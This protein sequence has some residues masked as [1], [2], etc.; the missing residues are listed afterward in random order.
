M[1]L[2]WQGAGG[3]HPDNSPRGQEGGD[4]GFPAWAKT[5]MLCRS[6]SFSLVPHQVVVNFESFINKA[7]LSGLG[8]CPVKKRPPSFSSP[9]SGLG[10]PMDARFRLSSGLFAPA[11]KGE[12]HPKGGSPG[13]AWKPELTRAKNFLTQSDKTSR[14]RV[15][16]PGRPAYDIIAKKR[17]YSA[18]S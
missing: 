11:S 9:S 18:A 15:V 4:T 8:L 1:R 14:A 12:L 10:T 7:G 17:G 13:G 6:F 3:P 2:T 5:P 16:F